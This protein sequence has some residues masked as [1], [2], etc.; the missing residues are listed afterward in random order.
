MMGRR[1]GA[2]G[3]AAGARQ[4]GES[5][6]ARVPIDTLRRLSEASS[7]SGRLGRTTFQLSP[8]QLADLREFSKRLGS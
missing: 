3:R 5:V 4:K 7:V 6:V 2:A 1:V 8:Q